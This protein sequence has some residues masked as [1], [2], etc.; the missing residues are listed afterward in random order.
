MEPRGPVIAYH[1]L[2]VIGWRQWTREC[3]N[4]QYRE[5]SILRQFARWFRWALDKHTHLLF[6]RRHELVGVE[7]CDKCGGR[8]EF[9]RDTEEWTESKKRPRQWRHTSFGPMY[10]F[11]ED[12]PTA[13]HDGFDGMFVIDMSTE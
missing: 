10:G 6:E 5:P 4:Q 13:Y 11:C 7:E 8:V 3:G 1:P 2:P 9:W 12:C